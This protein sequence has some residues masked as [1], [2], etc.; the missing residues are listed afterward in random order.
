MN[1]VCDILI[2]QCHF[3]LFVIVVIMFVVISAVII[4]III[5]LV[6]CAW[7]IIIGTMDII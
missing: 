4:T 1:D 2:N 7:F 6:T 3:R 5:P